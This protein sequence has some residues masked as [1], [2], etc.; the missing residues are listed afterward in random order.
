MLSGDFA[1]FDKLDTD[2]DAGVSMLE[3]HTFM[4]ATYKEKGAK[5]A[6]KWVTSLLHT[7]RQ[8]ASSEEGDAKPAPDAPIVSQNATVESNSIR[9]ELRQD[10][11]DLFRPL[12][13]LHSNDGGA[14]DTVSK[15]ELV[16]AQQGDFGIFSQMDL[17]LRNAFASSISPTALCSG[18]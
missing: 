5:K 8:V 9:N 11:V 16:A 18:R 17:G 4:R 14:R 1:L 3:W 13:A 7:L 15:A 2:G 10:A 6:V 12:A